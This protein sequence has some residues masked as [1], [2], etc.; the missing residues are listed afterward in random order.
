[1]VLPGHS[2]VYMVTLVTFYHDAIMHSST[3]GYIVYCVAH[4]T[5]ICPAKRCHYSF[6][7]D[8]AKCQLSFIFD[9]D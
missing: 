7:S 3:V 5:T 2:D 9:R 4:Y 6:G 8:F 1:M